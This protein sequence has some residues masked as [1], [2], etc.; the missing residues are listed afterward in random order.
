M[1]LGD[2]LAGLVALAAMLAACLAAAALIERRR[3]PWLGGVERVLA[4][5]LIATAAVLGVHVIPLALGLLSI[6]A[7]LV[8][9]SL[10]LVGAWFCPRT[11]RPDRGLEAPVREAP[12][13]PPAARL[14]AWVGLGLVVLYGLAV[15]RS[16]LVVVPSSIDFST[17]HLPQVA[18]WL[19]TG[20]LWQI[21]VFVP[22]VSPGHYP[23]SGDVLL[24]AVTLPWSNDFLAHLV[25]YP[26]WILTGVSVYALARHLGAV[27]SAATIAGCLFMAVPALSVSSLSAGLVDSFALFGLGTGLLFLLRHRRSPSTAELVLAGL[28]L[29]VAFGTKWYTVL[30]VVVVVTAWTGARLA[31]RDDLA[32]LARQAVVLIGVIAL[33][34]GVWM[35]RNL[36][37]SGNPVF[38]VEL[39]PFGM[40]IF[41]APPDP[42]RAAAG[43]TLANYLTQPDVWAEYILPQLRQ[44]WAYT[45]A[46][47]LAGGA[48]AGLIAT[49]RG[50]LP[51]AGVVRAG[52]A[53]FALLLVA[54]AVTPYTAG[55]PEGMPVLVGADSRYG[56]PALLVAA[57]LAAW[58]IS[59]RAPLLVVSCTLGLLAVRDSLLAS[60]QVGDGP[61][62]LFS[63]WITA[64]AAFAALAVL[65]VVAR[66]G[67][68]TLAGATTLVLCIGAIAGGHLT[69]ARFNDERYHELDPVFDAIAEAAPADNR[70]GLTGV[71]TDVGVAPVLPAFGPRFGNE[72]V[73]VGR[74]I[75]HVLNRY[76]D[77]AG[78]LTAVE[79]GGFDY[80]VVGT[81][82]PGA[83]TVKE[84]A[85]AR[86]AG[87][88]QVATSE[89]LLLLRAPERRS[90]R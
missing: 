17:F 26:F 78:F 24:L 5:G 42:V 89:R 90:I 49:M 76:S 13:D 37:E 80:L 68:R 46:L 27:R 6:P 30:S 41:S 63:D 77:R 56:L 18:G 72:V 84:G 69:Q 22:N 12:L 1:P 55:G 65:V 28:G 48:G 75:E 86:S 35:L 43:F 4:F 83:P 11:E 57:P 62:L 40:T 15:L 47:L 67:R 7:V 54:Y 73:Y 39:A 58:V 60:G 45:G 51:S 32:T 33:S 23:N 85:W 64:L 74:K 52:A 16:R 19:A 66:S 2:Y 88:E 87:F 34:G 14:L 44:F 10:V 59:L 79:E 21:D 9:S 36:V 82:R 71:W 50:R 81:G 29:G 31:A 25:M 70:I 3:L 61:T 20:S 8:T 53:C 38:P